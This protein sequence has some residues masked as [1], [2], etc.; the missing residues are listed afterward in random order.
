MG[1]AVEY[2]YTGFTDGQITPYPKHLSTL[3]FQRQAARRPG[4][5]WDCCFSPRPL[6]ESDPA[7]FAR[8]HHL[9][10]VPPAGGADRQRSQYLL[11]GG[12]WHPV[13]VHF[14]LAH[15]SSHGGWDWA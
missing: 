7:S 8:I 2:R 15:G 1:Q 3:E 6:P 11:E 12:R 5:G 9:L 14:D 10:S 4:D 13:P